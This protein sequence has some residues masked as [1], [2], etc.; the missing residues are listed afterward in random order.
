MSMRYVDALCSFLIE[1]GI[2]PLETSRPAVSM[3]GYLDIGGI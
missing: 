3:P 2:L 1:C